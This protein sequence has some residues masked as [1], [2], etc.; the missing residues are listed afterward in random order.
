[1]HFGCEGRKIHAR[2]TE[3]QLYN[4]KKVKKVKVTFFNRPAKIYVSRIKEQ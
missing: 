3:F 4:F 2:R 1:M